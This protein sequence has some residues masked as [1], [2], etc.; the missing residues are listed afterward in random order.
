MVSIHALTRSA[1]S[2]LILL[3]SLSMFQST[4]SRGVR[5]YAWACSNM[6]CVVSIHALT[7]SATYQGAHNCNNASFNP[8]THEEC[9]D[10]EV[11]L[12]LCYSVSIHALTRSAT[13]QNRPFFCRRSFNPRTHEECDWGKPVIL[14]LMIMFQSTHSRGVRHQIESRQMLGQVSIHALTR[15]A[16]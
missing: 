9:D 2:I 11:P 4:H 12:E 15:S 13:K 6:D 5:L 16:T 1:T 3:P 10:W 7:R 14:E 8:R